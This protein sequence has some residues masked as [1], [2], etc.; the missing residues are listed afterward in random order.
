MLIDPRLNK[1]DDC[2]Y[3]VAVRV[4]II[5]AN[6]VLLIK[7]ETDDW[8]A[9]PGGG[10]NHGET[11][12]SALIRELHEELGLSTEAISSNYN[13]VHYNIGNVVNAIPRM[14]FFIKA[15]LSGD[16]LKQA[17]RGTKWDWFSK[18]ELLR[19]KL[20]PTSDKTQLSKV[21]YQKI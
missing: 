2:L 16:S 18:N 5:H 13:V 15:T 21:I 6:K 9:L 12:E 14:N 1:I 17:D 11:I 4:I 8:W 7:E 19:A 3:R 20:H 10:V